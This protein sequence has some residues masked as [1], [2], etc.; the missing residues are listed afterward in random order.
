ML[1]Q[2]QARL[3]A[4][5]VLVAADDQRR[6]RRLPDRFRQRVDRGPAALK[7]RMVLAEPFELC[8]ASAA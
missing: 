3:D 4:S 6:R 1:L 7:P 8:R 2:E 5:V